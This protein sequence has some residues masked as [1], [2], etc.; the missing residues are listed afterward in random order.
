MIDQVMA[1]LGQQ[2]QN[3]VFAGGAALELAGGAAA[4]VHRLL[5]WACRI[6][7]AAM[8]TSVTMFFQFSSAMRKQLL[9]G[10]D[11]KA[12]HSNDEWMPSRGGSSRPRNLH[13]TCAQLSLVC[14][15][16]SRGA[17]IFA[18]VFSIACINTFLFAIPFQS[19]RTTY[20]PP[21]ISPAR[22]ILIVA[23]SLVGRAEPVRLTAAFSRK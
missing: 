11:I 10:A 12:A 22:R 17:I 18:G 6:V 1:W 3:G 14:G 9:D 13:A 4:A 16:S 15:K 20:P 7:R 19:G 21:I 23:S 2:M 5:P 8:M